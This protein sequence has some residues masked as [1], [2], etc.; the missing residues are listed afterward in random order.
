MIRINDEESDWHEGLTVADL[1]GELDDTGHYAVV[2][3]NHK[4]VS[5]PYFEKTVIPDNADVFLLPM[6]SG[7]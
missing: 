5:R 6:I 2:R 7:G 4:Y 1:L 3:I